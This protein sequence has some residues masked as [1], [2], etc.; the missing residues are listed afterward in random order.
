M[1][2]SFNGIIYVAGGYQGSVDRCDS[3]ECY[4]EHDNRWEM[5]GIILLEPIEASLMF[6]VE[7]KIIFVGG[8]KKSGDSDEVWSYDI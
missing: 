1:S 3:F 5:M 7:P 4:N 6:V 8:R 2:L